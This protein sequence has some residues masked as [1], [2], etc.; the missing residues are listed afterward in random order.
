ML[1]RDV[2]NQKAADRH[3]MEQEAGFSQK[4]E[5]LVGSMMGIEK[6]YPE[7]YRRIVS[8]A[9]RFIGKLPDRKDSMTPAQFQSEFNYIMRNS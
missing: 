2:E 5:N 4:I 7:T 6:D 1:N 9:D 3:E 8:L